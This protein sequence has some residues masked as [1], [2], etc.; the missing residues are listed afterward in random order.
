MI[1]ENLSVPAPLFSVII[2]LEY[3]RGQWEECWRAWKAQTTDP[4]LT[5]FILVVPPDFTNSDLLQQLSPARLEF[6]TATHDMGLCTLGATKARGKYLIFT[7]AHC[8]P[9]PDVIARC[10][11][12]I[13]TNPDWAGFSCRSLPITHNRLSEAEAVMYEADIEFAMQVHPWR[14]ILD[15]CFVTSREAYERCGGFQPQFGHFAEWLLAASYFRQGYKL[16]Y[17]PTAR[18]HHYY[19]GSLGE[20][21]DFTRDFVV[22]EVSYFS[23][24]HGQAQNDLEAGLEDGLLEL[25]EEWICQGNL[26]RDMSRAVLHLAM[27]SLRSPRWKAYRY[28]PRQVIE[29]GRWIPTAISGDRIARLCASA[30]AIVARISLQ[31]AVAAGPRDWLHDRFRKYIAA[32]IHTQRLEAIGTLR[33]ARHNIPQPGYVGLGPDAL[34]ADAAGF[35]PLE[36]YQGDD[37]RWSETAAAVRVFAAAG[38]QDIS[39]D[40]IPARD[41]MDT[42]SDFRFYIDRVRVRR[43]QMSIEGGRIRIALDLN[44]PRTFILG[45]TCLPFPAV[46]DPRQLGLPIKR[47]ELIGSHIEDLAPRRDRFQFAAAIA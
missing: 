34:A 4:S 11:E 42:R 27:Q 12:A 32:L 25:P 35:Y 41:L 38:P 1:S 44:Q 33:R 9:E 18:F 5:E 8:W 26:D 20:L 2:P 36:K 46:A 6:S 16:G 37:F 21:N 22:G 17:F 47:I 29:I 14:K 23:E 39:I 19:S 3:H 45:W 24:A 10:R 13:D 30:A 15:Q 28:L 43:S 40:C 7:E 31:L